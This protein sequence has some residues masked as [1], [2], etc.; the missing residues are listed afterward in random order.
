MSR[1]LFSRGSRG[2]IIRRIQ[3]SL[4]RGGYYTGSLDGLFGGGTERAVASY[5]RDKA[6]PATGSVDDVTWKALTRARI[7]TIHERCLQLTAAFEGH[8]YGMI[9]GNWDGA[10]LT[11]GIIGF[12]LKHG[13]IGRIVL[14][15][16]TKHPVVVREAFGSLTKELLAA[17]R[18]PGA[19][20]EAWANRIS[21]GPR[22]YAVAEPWRAAF[23]RFGNHD[24]VQRVQLRR[25]HAGYFAPAT[26]TARTFQLRTERGI[27]L[28]FDA[29]VQNGGIGPQARAAIDAAIASRPPQDERTLCLV[30]AHAIAENAKPA[31]RE[32]VRSRKVTIATGA[33]A[34]HGESFAL[35]R[36]GLDEHAWE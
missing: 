28:C 4:A 29:H 36:W 15:V 13:E 14:E 11:W 12:T 18:A 1:G 20:Q 8:G 32:D 34:V 30:I 25:V 21:L 22:R 10:W 35:D 24:T 5:Q 31:Y 3:Q 9:Q 17:L 27:A 7:P 6:L 19:D 16:Q 2:A 33:G 26:V 23:E